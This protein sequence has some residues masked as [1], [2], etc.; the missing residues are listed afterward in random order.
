MLR[1]GAAPA[2]WTQRQNRGDIKS[3][4]LSNLIADVVLPAVMNK[5]QSGRDPFCCKEN[6]YLERRSRIQM[7][8]FA[9]IV[10]PKITGL[11]QIEE[12]KEQ[13]MFYL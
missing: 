4:I 12:E 1:L 2:A 9:S 5:P 7:H 6:K 11:A 10:V 3:N 13:T 8:I